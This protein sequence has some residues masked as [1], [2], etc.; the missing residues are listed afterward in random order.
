[1]YR[2]SVDSRCCVDDVLEDKLTAVA[3]NEHLEV[4]RQPAGVGG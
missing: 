2:R 4:Q 3:Q 1:M